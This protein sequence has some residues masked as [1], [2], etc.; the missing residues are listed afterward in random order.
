[1]NNQYNVIP[2]DLDERE[3]LEEIRE[4]ARDWTRGR[5][6]LEDYA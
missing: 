1:M 5:P 2:F 6:E 4:L 3:Q